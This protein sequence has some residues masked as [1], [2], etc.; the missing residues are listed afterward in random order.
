MCLHS[1]YDRAFLVIGTISDGII[2]GH[3]STSNNFTYDR[4]I[5]VHNSMGNN[6]TYDGIIAWHNYTGNNRYCMSR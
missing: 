4:I 3:N 6:C 1:K 5:A 2:A